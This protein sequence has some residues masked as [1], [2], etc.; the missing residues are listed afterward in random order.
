[1][2]T[3][4]AQRIEEL[5]EQVETEESPS[6]AGKMLSFSSPDAVTIGKFLR[7]LSP[8]FREELAAWLAD[9]NGEDAINRANTD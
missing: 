4:V 2:P 6:L 3:K 8:E 5:M 1:M 7:E 9:D